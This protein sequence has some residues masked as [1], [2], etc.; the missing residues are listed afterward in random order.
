MATG[1]SMND[2]AVD[3]II[4]G[5][6]EGVVR[7]QYC[8]LACQ[9]RIDWFNP[10]RGIIDLKS[11][12]DLTWFEADARRY[13]YAHQL[14][15]YRAVVGELTGEQVPVHLIAVE[16]KEPY[17][18][19]VWVIPDE[20]LAVARRENEDAIGR[21]IDCESSGAWPSGYEDIRVFD[22]I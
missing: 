9:S 2:N 1:L 3:L 17:R 14:A 18:C 21:L 12:D 15:F 6:A 22:Y 10:T 16:K 4:E 7:A 20:V 13:G 19:G 5:V 8:G 11:C